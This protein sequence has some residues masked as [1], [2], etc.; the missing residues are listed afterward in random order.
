MRYLNLKKQVQTVCLLLSFFVLILSCYCCE[1]P[2]DEDDGTT[3]PSVDWT[4]ADFDVL[5]GLN[6]GG[7]LSQTSTRNVAPER[8]FTKNEIKKCAEWGFDHLRIPVD[9]MEI[10]TENDD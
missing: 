4:T 7:W 5:R 10:F 3:L 2:T 8:F 9:E 1:S 6:I